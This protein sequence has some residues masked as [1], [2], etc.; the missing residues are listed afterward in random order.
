[1]PGLPG[2]PGDSPSL[3]AVLKYTL[4]TLGNNKGYS[5]LELL[6]KKL[7]KDLENYIYFF[8]LRNHGTILNIPVTELIYIIAI[9]YPN[10]DYIGNQ[11][12]FDDLIYKYNKDKPKNNQIAYVELR[13]EEFPK[14]S[15]KKI[16]RDLIGKE[17]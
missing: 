17:K 7:G 5:L 11:E 6:R 16:V 10:E 8:S 13:S 2:V 12:Y 4:Q 15:S 14:N 1:M 3:T 9:I